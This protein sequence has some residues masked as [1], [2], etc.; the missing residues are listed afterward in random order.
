MKIGKNWKF[1]SE[2]KFLN[3]YKIGMQIGKGQYGEVRVC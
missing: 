2:G 1:D 3:R